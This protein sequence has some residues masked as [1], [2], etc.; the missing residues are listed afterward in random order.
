MASGEGAASYLGDPGC[1]GS[2]EIARQV[3]NRAFGT[4]SQSD[5]LWF[6]LLSCQ[7]RIVRCRLPKVVE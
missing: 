6:G 7:G 4:C 1:P 3:L 2:L 5:S